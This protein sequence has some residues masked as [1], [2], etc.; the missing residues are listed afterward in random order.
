[1]MCLKHSIGIPIL[2]MPFLTM[3]EASTL[4]KFPFLHKVDKS[5]TRKLLREVI[6]TI[7]RQQLLGWVRLLI[8]LFI[9]VNTEAETLTDE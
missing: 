9:F 2:Y 1:M 3:F 5:T 7:Q 4:L 8:S 6:N